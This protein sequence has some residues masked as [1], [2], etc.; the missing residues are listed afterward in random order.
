MQRDVV[1]LGSGES[2]MGAALLAKNKGLNVFVSD[3]SIITK[4]NRDLLDYNNIEWEENKHTLEK[5][6][7]TKEVIKSPGIPNDSSFIKKLS[8]AD[9]KIVSE[10]EF[11][12]RYTNT[13]I[14]AITGSN[15]KTTT[16]NLVYYIF[17]NAGYN[18]FLPRIPNL[19]NL[20][21]V[22]ENV[23][24]FAHCYKELC[25]HKIIKS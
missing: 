17:K 20:I 9:V 14:I 22:K 11:A 16:T 13:K 1:V 4:E 12:F 7:N 23:S 18:V 15:G 24:W 21:L 2:G 6:I 25:K 5:I 19:K 8:D 3:S 10:I